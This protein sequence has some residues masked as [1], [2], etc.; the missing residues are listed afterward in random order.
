MIGYVILKPRGMTISAP[1]QCYA[2]IKEI[3]NHIMT[4]ADALMRT[5]ELYVRSL[6]SGLRPRCQKGR[7]LWNRIY[8]QNFAATL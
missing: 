6:V 7:F 8:Q 1:K 5:D 2:S 3:A 4:I